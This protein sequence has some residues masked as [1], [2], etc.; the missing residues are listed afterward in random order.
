MT[1]YVSSQQSTYGIHHQKLFSNAT[2]HLFDS[3]SKMESNFV[4][5]KQRKVFP[6]KLDRIPK[7]LH[8]SLC[9]Y[10]ICRHFILYSEILGHNSVS[11]RKVQQNAEYLNRNPHVSVVVANKWQIGFYFSY[12]N[13]F[14]TQSHLAIM[15]AFHSYA[16]ITLLASLF[17]LFL[18]SDLQ[19]HEIKCRKMLETDKTQ[20]NFRYVVSY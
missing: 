9:K 20:F 5:L 4:T 17:I 13:T 10:C 14:R 8:H 3:M 11:V 18:N 1:F 7:I 16:C 2:S 12:C 15:M 6:L 19:E